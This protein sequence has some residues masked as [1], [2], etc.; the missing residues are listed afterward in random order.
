MRRT[1]WSEKKE[2]ML[3]HFNQYGAKRGNTAVAYISAQRSRLI[4]DLLTTFTPDELA[5]LSDEELKHLASLH[6]DDLFEIQIP[7]D[8]LR[9]AQRAYAGAL[10]QR[11]SIATFRRP[12][13]R[14][15]HSTRPA[16]ALPDPQEYDD[17]SLHISG[18]FF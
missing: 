11:S 8:E 6:G 13:C 4:P 16:P 7:P 15:R 2:E 5:T 3:V 17:P 9:E 18:P 12:H 1:V 10:I 14:L